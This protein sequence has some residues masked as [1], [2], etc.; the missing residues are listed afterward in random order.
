MLPKSGHISSARLSSV[1]VF[2][3]CQVRCQLRFITGIHLLIFLNTC[4]TPVIN[5]NAAAG[6][7]NPRAYR[8]LADGHAGLLYD[9]YQKAMQN[10]DLERVFLPRGAQPFQTLLQFSAAY[11]GTMRD[12]RSCGVAALHTGLPLYLLKEKAHLIPPGFKAKNFTGRLPFLMKVGYNLCCLQILLELRHSIYQPH[13][14]LFPDLAELAYCLANGRKVGRSFGKGMFLLSHAHLY[15]VH[16]S[17]GFPEDDAG[18]L[19]Q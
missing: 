13:K 8:Q 7:Q 14:A 2:C 4:R 18:R 6:A 19:W 5:Q 3:N 15:A 10:D 9:G 11:T 12:M 17:A 16:S 1:Q